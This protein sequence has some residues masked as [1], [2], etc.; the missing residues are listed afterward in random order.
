MLVEPTKSFTGPLR[1]F[2][3]RT[4]HP[5]VFRRVVSETERR[6]RWRDWRQTEP[7]SFALGIELPTPLMLLKGRKEL[8]DLA[9]PLPGCPADLADESVLRDVAS[10]DPLKQK[11]R[12]DGTKLERRR[13]GLSPTSS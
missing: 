4:L 11:G 9:H 12:A 2:R 7:D 1:G 5:G 13:P 8:R 6:Y 3:W 10:Q